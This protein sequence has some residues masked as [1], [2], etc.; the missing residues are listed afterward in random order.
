MNI[1]RRLTA[2]NSGLVPIILRLV[3]G[4]VMVP[5]GAQKLLGWFG[6]QGFEATIDTFQ[7]MFGLPPAVTALVIV[8][9]FFGGLALLAGVFSRLAA[10]G[11][12]AVMVGAVVTVHARNGF[13]MDWY[14]TQNGQGFE[15]HLLA[16]GLATAVLLSG[17]G[18]FS[19]DRLIAHR[20]DAR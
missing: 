18:A 19:I 13:F 2:T 9:E 12:G 14:G 8:I 16:L 5:H 17:S 20:V 15:Y 7:A 11:L 3:L 4:L 6:G 10:L 1:L